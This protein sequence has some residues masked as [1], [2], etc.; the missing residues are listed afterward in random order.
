MT[1]RK[2][3]AAFVFYGVLYW[4]ACGMDDQELQ[5]WVGNLRLL[6]GPRFWEHW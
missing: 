2:D 1:N 5:R 4:P 6:F 3:R